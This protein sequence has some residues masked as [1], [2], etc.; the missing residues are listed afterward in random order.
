MLA[1][2]DIDAALSALRLLLEC[3]QLVWRASAN[4]ISRSGVK[5]SEHGVARSTKSGAGCRQLQNRWSIAITVGDGL[6]GR[7]GSL[8]FS[9][10]R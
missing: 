6:E 8:N 5:R 3:V 9:M 2:C 7:T 10:Y 4:Y 1:L